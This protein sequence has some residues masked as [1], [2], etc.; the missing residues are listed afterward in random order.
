M[1][2]SERRYITS[3]GGLL[4]LLQKQ[5]EGGNPCVANP[6]SLSM[7]LLAQQARRLGL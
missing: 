6:T 2:T 1:Q 7:L 5:Q 4:D 3:Q